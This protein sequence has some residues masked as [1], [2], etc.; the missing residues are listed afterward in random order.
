MSKESVQFDLLTALLVLVPLPFVAYFLHWPDVAVFA[1]ACLGIIPLAGLMGKA[2]EH[3]S[4]H[5]GPGKGALLNAFF[6]NACEFILALSALNA[7]LIDVVKASITGSIMGNVLLVLGASMFAGGLRNATQTFNRTAASTSAT[8]LALAA[9]GL[10]MPT[11]LHHAH[12]PSDPTG[13]R[14][15]MVISIVL[16]TVYAASL[17]F[18]LRTHKSVYGMPVGEEGQLA[19]GVHGWSKKKSVS[20]LLASTVVVALIA[21]FLVGAVE[22]TGHAL[23]MSDFFVGVILVA[24]VGNAAENSSAVLMAL[25][26]R[27][28]LSIN[29]ALGSSIQ[30]AL[31][32]A[33]LLVFIGYF[34]GKPMNLMFTEAEVV[35][36]IV[37]VV[38]LKFVATDGE[39]NWLEGLML[40]A[41]YAI[42]G[43]AFF[44][45]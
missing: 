16:S 40:L 45:L 32:I 4:E 8:L 34:M 23:G 29:I 18:S 11:V 30:L 10:L 12:S 15:S 21:Q 17:I 24:I 14:V 7:G 3:L 27:M 31:L 26:N 1:T 38:G 19:L 22:Q 9:I 33:P 42:L 43:A 6:G 36:V 35:A 20:I 25:K 13:G 44:Y 28:D 37:A 41:I 2:T 5:V 39:S